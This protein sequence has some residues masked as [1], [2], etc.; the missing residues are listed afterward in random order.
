MTQVFCQVD[1]LVS[2]GPGPNGERRFV[3]LGGGTVQGRALNGT[4]VEGGVDWPI[5]RAD[6]AQA[7]PRTV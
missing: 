1:A 7:S 3:P 2:L 6:G 5:N 4:L